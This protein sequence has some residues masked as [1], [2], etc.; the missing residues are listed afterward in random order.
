KS[1]TVA[2]NDKAKL[3]ERLAA[4]R[5]LAHA[6][7]ELAEPRLT[8]LMNDPVQ[9]V[10]LA[11]VRSLATHNR[12]E[13][14]KLLMKGWRSTT[15]A[16]R[17]EVLEA[18][19]RQPARITVLLD[20]VQ[21]KRVKPGDIDSLRT[22]QLLGHGNA[23]IRDRAKKLLRDNLPGDRKLV[24]A[25]YQE[26]L[27][28]KGDAKAGREI[29]KKNCAT[30]HRVAGIGVDVGPD[31]ADTRTKT[32]GGLLVDI[33]DPNQAIDNNAISYLVTTK[34][35]KSL[36]GL[37]AAENASSVTLRRAEGQTDVILRQDIE[38]I[39][40]TG[41]SLMPE[42]F[43]K[44]INIAEMADL[45]SFLKNWRYLDGNVPVGK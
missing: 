45:L 44:S 43:E 30:C 17:R 40:S 22:R 37:I 23:D 39:V 41:E 5:L 11:A 26:A 6:S 34:S 19:L 29:F 18:M 12:P 13:V 35:G 38:R 16:V 31:I 36:T 27:K 14:S 15:P 1:A 9:D 33:L 32:L 8:P 25:R 20:E 42:G 4:I 28:L 21:A 7:W 10:R 24:I 2:V 3:G